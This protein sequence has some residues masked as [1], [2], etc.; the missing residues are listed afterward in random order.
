M[1]YASDDATWTDGG[2]LDRYAEF[3]KRTEDG[4]HAV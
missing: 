3:L 2:T 1:D 4:E